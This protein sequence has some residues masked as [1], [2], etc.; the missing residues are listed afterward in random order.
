MDRLRKTT[1]ALLIII[2]GLLILTIIYYNY[3]IAS[4]DSE[5]ALLSSQISNQTEEIE[6][7]RNQ[8]ADLKGIVANLTSQIENM[9][10]IKAEI[11]Y[12]SEDDNFYPMAGLAVAI[13]FDVH[14]SNTGAKDIFDSTLA[15][16]NIGTNTV[17]RGIYTATK[18]IDVIQAK[19]TFETS[20]DNHITFW[21][22]LGLNKV[23]EARSLD[24]LVTL[25][26]DET[27]LDQETY[28]HNS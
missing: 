23:Q 5:I 11:T 1:S 6:S 4:K 19:Q 20:I 15:L 25:K 12:I 13:P 21:I 16:E 28:Y 22:L 18:T 10:G 26:L 14:I 8:I 7:L 17:P 2:L 27:L 9:T 24:Y 3:S